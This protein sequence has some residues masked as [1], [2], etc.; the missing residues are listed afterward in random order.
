MCILYIYMYMCTCGCMYMYT[1]GSKLYDKQK[2]TL[3]ITHLVQ[4]HVLA[5]YG[6]QL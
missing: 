5:C 6:L 2:C 4:V 1:V 3:N